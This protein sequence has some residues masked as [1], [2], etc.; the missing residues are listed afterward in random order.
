MKLRSCETAAQ[1]G[2]D[3]RVAL[4]ERDLDQLRKS[5]SDLRIQLAKTAELKGSE[6][7][8]A[9]IA[10]LQSELKRQNA[11]NASYR[12][13]LQDSERQ[14]AAL[15]LRADELSARSLQLENADRQ[16]DAAIA[17]LRAQV[18]QFESEKKITG[19][20]VAICNRT[21]LRTKQDTRLK[22]EAKTLRATANADV[23]AALKQKDAAMASKKSLAQAAKLLSELWNASLDDLAIVAQNAPPRRQTTP[24][25]RHPRH[26]Q[27]RQIPRRRRQIN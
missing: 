13:R 25:G 4:L 14:R 21:V 6:Q 5:E 26:R 22:E 3:Q 11:E 8:K 27:R 2:C 20:A 23:E 10:G 7:D 19:N 15:S 16:R 12:L 24:R 9:T 1:R 17:S 18:G